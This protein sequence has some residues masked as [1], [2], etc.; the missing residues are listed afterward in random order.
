MSNAT[1]INGLWTRCSTEELEHLQQAGGSV[2]ELLKL[3]KGAISANAGVRV[4][5]QNLS[6]Q[7][8]CFLVAQPVSLGIYMY[9]SCQSEFE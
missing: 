3:A 1:T 8:S 9:E 7:M 4:M 6:R 2:A 5:F